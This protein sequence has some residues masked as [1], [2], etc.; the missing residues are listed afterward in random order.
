MT[1]AAAILFAL[2][3]SAM[4]HTGTLAEHS[5]F[6]AGFMHPLAGLDHLIAIVLAG[7][8]AAL[9][10]GKYRVVL[11]LVFLA[12]MGTGFAVALQ[13]GTAP[14]AE[15]AILLSLAVFGLVIAGMIR[16]RAAFALAVAG[17]FAFAHGAAH[18]AEIGGASAISYAAGFLV[19]TAVVLATA[20]VAG[21]R[22]QTGNIPF[23]SRIAG[24]MAV[25]ASLFLALN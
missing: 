20:C 11:P 16:L 21:K 2:T 15:G 6:A 22:I 17:G 7:L 14:Y 8:W 24:F 19:A 18:G 13:T 9:L 5:S 1:P 23:V 12:T 25:G 10:G 3:A 4:A